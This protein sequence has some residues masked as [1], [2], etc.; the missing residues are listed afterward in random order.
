MPDKIQIWA[1]EDNIALELP[2]GQYLTFPFN[3][4]ARL[5]AFLRNEAYRVREHKHALRDLE[6]EE[7]ARVW[8][9]AW[10]EKGEETRKKEEKRKQREADK[11]KSTLRRANKAQ[12]TKEQR[13]L[14][15]LVGL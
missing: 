7:R 13:E 9:K 4:P 6:R 1:T 5:V 2:D 11:F 14:L 10:K 3:E 12:E 8:A 15:K